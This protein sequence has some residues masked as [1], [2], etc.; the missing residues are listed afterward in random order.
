MVLVLRICMVL[1]TSLLLDQRCSNNIENSESS[2][3]K[4]H[5][6]APTKSRVQLVSKSSRKRNHRLR[7]ACRL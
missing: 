3:A 6:F 5:A 2:L 1:F 4:T 7:D